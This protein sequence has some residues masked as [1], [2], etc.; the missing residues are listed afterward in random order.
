MKTKLKNH[1]YMNMY[2]V[3]C[4]SR[5]MEDGVLDL[6]PCQWS[7]GPSNLPDSMKFHLLFKKVKCGEVSARGD[8]HVC[9]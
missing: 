4:P 6:S 5:R 8:D 1:C 2:I 9:N 3:T 7:T